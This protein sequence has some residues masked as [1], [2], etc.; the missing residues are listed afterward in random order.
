MLKLIIVMI[1]KNIDNKT[2]QKYIKRLVEGDRRSCFD[3][4]QSLI[5]KDIELEIIYKELFTKSM[6]EIG[7]LWQK[8]KITVTVEHIATSITEQLI[9][10]LYPKILG[11]GQNK[12][13]KYLGACVPGELHQLGGKMIA[14]LMELY[15]WDSFFAGANTPEEDLLQEIKRI[16]PDLIGLSISIFFNFDKM[17]NLIKSIQSS[18]PD[19]KIITGGHAFTL[20]DNNILSDFKN[21]RLI[22]DIDEL[23][24]LSC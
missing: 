1:M 19:L 15:G 20:T 7:Y 17:K 8:N 5:E 21:V 11:S 2:Y 22:K 23:K 6:Y 10:S 24:R 3:I 12:A 13:C 4:V 9:S 16:R 18:F 14:D